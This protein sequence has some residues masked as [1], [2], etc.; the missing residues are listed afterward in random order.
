MAKASISISNN[1]SNKIDLELN[2]TCVGIATN[3]D[4]NATAERS[5][6]TNRTSKFD[7]WSKRPLAMHPHQ[8]ALHHPH[9]QEQPAM[10][11][12]L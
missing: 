7:K 2:R 4:W 8:Q 10:Q 6:V 1:N 3:L 12:P 5:S 11:D 9:L